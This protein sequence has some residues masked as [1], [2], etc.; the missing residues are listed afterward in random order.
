MHVQLQIDSQLVAARGCEDHVIGRQVVDDV[1]VL[2]LEVAYDGHIVA[3]ARR[4]HH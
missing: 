4:T 3:L 2:L 1:H